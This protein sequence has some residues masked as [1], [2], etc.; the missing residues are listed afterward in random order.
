M[1]GAVF[2]QDSTVFAWHCFVAGLRAAKWTGPLYITF[3]FVL[4][5]FGALRVQC[6]GARDFSAPARL[7]CRQK[8]KAFANI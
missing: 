7:V 4:R 2:M 3:N 6:L 8:F 1:V 5:T